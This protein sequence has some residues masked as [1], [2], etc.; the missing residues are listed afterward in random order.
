M[1]TGM[2]TKHLKDID[3]N[4]N[5]KVKNIIENMTKKEG[6]PVHNDGSIDRLEWVST[7][8]NYKNIAEEIVYNELIYC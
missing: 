1:M 7:M 3:L 6:I 8:N 4:A 2:L 5:K